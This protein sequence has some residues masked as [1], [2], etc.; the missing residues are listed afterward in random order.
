MTLSRST[1]RGVVLLLAALA[2][3]LPVRS[4]PVARAAE[5]DGGEAQWIWTPEQPDAEAPAG[6]CYFRKSFGLGQPESGQIQITA[7]DGF[8]LFVNGRL[9]GQGDDWH[10]LAVFDIL[11]FLNNGRNVVAVKVNNA[12]PGAAGLVVRLTVK[13]KGNTDV[14]YSSDGTWKVS[15]QEEPNWN[16]ARFDDSK[17]SPV[18]LLGELGRA[19]P[20]RNGVQLN[21]VGGGRFAVAPQFRV[22]RIAR[23]D[24]TGS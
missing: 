13:A 2:A 22:E 8:E 1:I 10:R 6:T 4:N 14:S 5:I 15:T 17:W 24:E 18:R 11:K 9:V 16:A 7:D 23:P 3:A 20:W 19:E 21:G 12:Q